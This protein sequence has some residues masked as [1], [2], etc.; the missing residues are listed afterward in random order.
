MGTFSTTC[1]IE[2]HLDRS[3][4]I[5]LQLMVDTG[6]E[7]TW[8]SKR[9]LEKLGIRREKKDVA[10]VMANGTHITRNVGFA[11]IRVGEH[12]TIDE[13]VFAED[14]DLLLLGARTLEGLNLT[15]DAA[16]KRLVGAGPL[17]VAGPI[18]VRR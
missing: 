18:R 12:L 15:I 13:V 9:T 1:R 2:N 3:K 17:P 14:G 5:D 4:T 6:S 8:V 16:R 11:V 7:S 10:F